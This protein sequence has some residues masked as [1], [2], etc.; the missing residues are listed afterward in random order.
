M[1]TFGERLKQTRK[2]L[3]LT[4]TELAELVGCAPQGIS[5][6]ENGEVVP[7]KAEIRNNLCDVLGVTE[8]WLFSGT[9]EK[10][11]SVAEAMAEEAKAEERSRSRV[12]YSVKDE[13]QLEDIELLIHHI[14]DM[15]IPLNKKR[16]IHRTL[17]DIRGELECKVLFGTGEIK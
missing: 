11:A 15:D 2:E 14:K 1:T 16:T 3:D 9:G 5:F 10:S 7:K 4:Q 13:R 17:S 6:Y 12:I 8:R